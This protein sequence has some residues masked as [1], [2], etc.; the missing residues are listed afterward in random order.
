[1]LSTS[2][3]PRVWMT[4][5]MDTDLFILAPWHFIARPGSIRSIWCDNGS[6]FVGAEKELEKCMN[7]MGNKRIGG[8]LLE[9]RADWI[10]WKKNPLIA[11]HVVGVWERQVRSVRTILSSLI[12]TQSMSPVEESWSTLFTEVEAIIN[13]GPVLVETIKNVNSEMSIS[14]SHIITMKSKVFMP[15]PG[16]FERVQS[17][18]GKVA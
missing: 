15:Q 6:N 11:S 8:F 1:M 18:E 14:D 17:G 9:K 10:V 12:R 13:W 5:S 7:E 3:W 4:K 2:G 16:V